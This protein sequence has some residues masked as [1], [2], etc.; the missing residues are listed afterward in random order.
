MPDSIDLFCHWLPP[1]FVEGVRRWS[2]GSLHMFNRAAAM[3]AM[4][5]LGARFRVMDEF[6]GYRQVPSIASPPIESVSDR[7]AAIDLARI[8]N[9]EQAETIAQHPDRFAGFV[10]VLP[11]NDPTA[12][13]AEAA[14]AIGTLGALGVQI[15]SNI[16][17]RPL[18]APEY[19]EV[20]RTVAA[21][22]RPLW[23]HPTRSMDF[24]DYRQEALSKF[25]LW[26]AF[27]WPYETSVAMGRLV[28]SGLFEDTPSV[29]IITHHAGGI[30]P[31]MEGRIASGLSLIGTRCAPGLE[32][33]VA[34]RLRSPPIDNFK[35]FYADTATFGSRA[36]IE[37]ARA[38]FGV[39][40][41]V[42][43]TDMPFDPEQGPGYIRSTLQAIDKLDVQPA[44]RAQI[45]A[46]NARRLC[47]LPDRA[48]TLNGEL[49]PVRG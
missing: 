48:A 27:G 49:V 38:F 4:G 1:R 19:L 6:P 11:M 28:F 47:G 25:D 41:L 8:A 10:A 43:A 45:L 32:H 36:A 29:R 35:R 24:P 12:A 20:I 16:N 7:S 18:D 2:A 26:W 39:D 44:E 13:Q 31:M 17:G 21:L 46:G 40:H 9:D 5:D 37:C 23:L 3:P 14:R 42:F 34:T 33:A 15:F 30:V 22:G